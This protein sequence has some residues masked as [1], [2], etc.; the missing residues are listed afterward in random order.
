MWPDSRR[1]CWGQPPFGPTEAATRLLFLWTRTPVADPDQSGPSVAAVVWEKSYLLE[2]R[3]TVVCRALAVAERPVRAG[4][5]AEFS[6]RPG[7]ID[8]RGEIRD[9]SGLEV[10]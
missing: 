3:A 2:V 1:S 7:E 4:P 5:R 8:F 10:P 6:P 9:A